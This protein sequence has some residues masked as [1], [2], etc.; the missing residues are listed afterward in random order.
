MVNKLMPSVHQ[1]NTENFD[2]PASA[3][4]VAVLFCSGKRKK[5]K[6]WNLCEWYRDKSKKKKGD[7]FWSLKKKNDK[8]L[9]KTFKYFD[10]FY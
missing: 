2:S 9:K 10:F 1:K 6:H 7:E 8:K 4:M 3:T 5:E